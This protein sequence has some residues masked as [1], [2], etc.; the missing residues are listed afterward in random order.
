[1][2]GELQIR[3]STG[4]TVY[5]Q[6]RSATG[7]IWNGTAF[8]TYDTANIATYDIA[9]VE[10]GT[11]SQI[12][13]GT[14]PA[15]ISAGT[16]YASFRAQAGGSPAETDTFVGLTSR[17]TEIQWSGSVILPRAAWAL[18][19]VAD[20][21]EGREWA[22]ERDGRVANTVTIA[23]T[24][25][26]TLSMNFDRF[27][28]PETS[29]S[30][31]DS[32]ADQSGNALSTSG[33]VLSGDKRKLYFDVAAADLTAA[34]SYLMRCSATTTDSQAISADGTLKTRA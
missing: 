26:V 27:M 7:A 19:S 2:A 8:E 10:Q 15:T 23:A 31:A 4:S 33:L 29:L 13:I 9:M 21:G 3:H 22:V 20:V 32:V 6:I 25:S 1:M 12:Y 24:D 18:V 14:F 28:N 17:Q 11:A 30:S 34:T 5:A 16:Y